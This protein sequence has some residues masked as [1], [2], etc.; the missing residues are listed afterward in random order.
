MGAFID[1]TGQK[2]NRL[3][4]LERAEN[5]K[6]RHARWKCL[7]DCGAHTVVGG[8]SLTRGTTKSC[9]CYKKEFDKQLKLE[10]GEADFNRIYKKYVTHSRE[11]GRAFEL[12]EDYFRKL[13][14]G[15]CYFCGLPPRQQ[16]KTAS[17]YLYNGVDRLDNSV[18]YT[19]ENCVSC[20]KECNFA[21]TNKTVEEFIIWIERVHNHL[22]NNK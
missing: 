9:G 4:V 13:T 2:F 1:L 6:C 18:G 19:K 12:T 8:Q 3:L 17:V 16:I 14:K 21:K 20:C 15:D 11:D 5:F 10:P 7:C 22:I